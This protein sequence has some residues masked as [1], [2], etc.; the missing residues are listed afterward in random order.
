M[1][2]PANAL[3]ARND[4]LANRRG[5]ARSGRPCHNSGSLAVGRMGGSLM[6]GFYDDRGVAASVEE[7]CPPVHKSIAPN[8]FY[9][10]P[11]DGLFL[12]ARGE[13]NDCRMTRD[14]LDVDELRI[15]QAL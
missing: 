8:I 9:T 6:Q 13:L 3:P 10:P 14:A 7:F 1:F 12:T 2:N 15:F 5:G 4:A 11:L